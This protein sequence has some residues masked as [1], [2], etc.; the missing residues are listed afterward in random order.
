M[1]F[2]IL[3]VIQDMEKFEAVLEAWRSAGVSGVTILPSVGMARIDHERALR[4]DMPLLP[5][6][7]NLFSQEEVLNRTL[8]TLV[9]GKEIVEQV[10]S[11]TETILGD[12][13]LP[14]TGILAVLPV[15]NVLGLHRK[16]G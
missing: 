6:L 4:E 10:I 16:E 8:F 1:T 5:M 11:A 14:D 15:D 13:D 7:S 3:L 2:L 12:L 9:E